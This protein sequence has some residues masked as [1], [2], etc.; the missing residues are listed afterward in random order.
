MNF[1]NGWEWI[2]R[3]GIEWD[4]ILQNQIEQML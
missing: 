3:F 2:E 4:G 1:D